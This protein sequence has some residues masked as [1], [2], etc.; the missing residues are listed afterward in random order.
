MIVN[1]TIENV[2]A[3]RLA[4]G[5]IAGLSVDVRITEI[6]PSGPE[7]LEAAFRYEAT[8]EK[9]LG[10]LA[11]NG[12]LLVRP[13]DA[14]ERTLVLQ[15]WNSKKQIPAGFAQ[16]VTNAAHYL[17][18]INA[19]LATRIVDLAPPIPPMRVEFSGG[20]PAAPSSARP[21]AP[22]ASPAARAGRKP[23]P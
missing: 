22:G 23:K 8:Y 11:M 20:Q 10:L 17:C 19:P 16:E 14:T 2:Q 5:P 12:R 4:N 15:T 1:G 6:R 13:A 21:P 3:Q 18:T 7:L 9:G